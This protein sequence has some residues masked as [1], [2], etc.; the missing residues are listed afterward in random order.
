MLLGAACASVLAGLALN[1]RAYDVEDY[2]PNNLCYGTSAGNCRLNGKEGMTC[3][4]CDPQGQSRDHH[5]PTPYGRV[6]G[7]PHSDFDGCDKHDNNHKQHYCAFESAYPKAAP[8]TTRTTATTTTTTVTNMPAE[9]TRCLAFSD[10][11]LKIYENECNNFL[12]MLRARG[13]PTKNMVCR[14]DFVGST[15]NNNGCSEIAATINALKALTAGSPWYGDLEWACVGGKDFG[16]DT[17]DLGKVNDWVNAPSGLGEP[18]N[19]HVKQCW[20]GKCSR[21]TDRCVAVDTDVE[22]TSTVA[23]TAAPRSCTAGDPTKNAVNGIGG[24]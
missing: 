19:S 10:G 1:V 11:A 8:P 14:D 23:T 3:F 21:S 16:L 17:C 6:G 7:R 13:V 12:A 15:D 22:E 5:L 20:T 2:H 18:C 9:F 24:Q 4:K